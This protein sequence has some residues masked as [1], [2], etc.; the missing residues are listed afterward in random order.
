MKEMPLEPM[1]EP[2]APLTKITPHDISVIY[3]AD[4]MMK[5]RGR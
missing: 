4:A 1:S 2:M 3:A 5:K